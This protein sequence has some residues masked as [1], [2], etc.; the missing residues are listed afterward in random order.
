LSGHSKLVRLIGDPRGI[1]N[2]SGIKIDCG[3]FSLDS[4]SAIARTV[5]HEMAHR[6]RRDASACRADPWTGKIDLHDRA[7]EIDEECF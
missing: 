1:E 5:L 3:H 6:A 2:S 4:A 7:D